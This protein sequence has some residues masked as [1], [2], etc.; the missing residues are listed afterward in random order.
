LAQQGMDEVLVNL[1]GFN[2]A[3]LDWARVSDIQNPEQYFVDPESDEAQQAIQ[4]K[5]QQAQEMER[6]KRALMQ[7]AVGLEQLQR[8]LDKYKHDSE[9]QFKYW[10]ETL[11]AEVEEA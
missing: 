1:S 2:R 6:M 8:A 5:Q 9:L 10:S 3:L 4:R 11:G 7:Q